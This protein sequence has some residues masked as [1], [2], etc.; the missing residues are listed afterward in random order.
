MVAASALHGLT[1]AGKYWLR[2]AVCVPV[3]IESD[4]RSTNPYT[5]NEHLIHIYVHL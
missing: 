1:Y 3:C 4:S 2:S 5:F